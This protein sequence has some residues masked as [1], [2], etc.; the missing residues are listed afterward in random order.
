M[1]DLIVGRLSLEVAVKGGDQGA[2]N[3]VRL[4]PREGTGIWKE[5]R[6]REW[7]TGRAA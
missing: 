1:C 6:N 4:K 7:R 2:V 3:V 5:G